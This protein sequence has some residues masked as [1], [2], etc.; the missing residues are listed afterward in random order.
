[1]SL[2]ITNHVTVA[3][4]GKFIVKDDGRS[5]TLIALGLAGAE[6]G[7]LQILAGSTYVNVWED[8]TQKQLTATNTAFRVRAKGEY[9]IVKSATAAAASIY[10]A[11]SIAGAGIVS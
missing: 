11:G 8:G 4:T 5:V 3:S 6:T 2:V 1:M 9:Q 7:S 10:L